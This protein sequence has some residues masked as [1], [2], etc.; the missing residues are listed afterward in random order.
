MRAGARCSV[1]VALL[2]VLLPAPAAGQATVRSFLT[3]GADVPVGSTFIVSV[4]VTGAGRVEAA[5]QA[6]DLSAWADY[7]GSGRSSQVSVVN[8]RTTSTVTWQFRY[9]AAGEGQHP[10]PPVTVEADGATFESNALEMRVVPARPGAPSSAGSADEGGLAPGDLFLTTEVPRT[11]VREGEPLP[12]SYRIWTRVNVTSYT[13]VEIPEMQGFWVEEVPSSGSPQVEQRTRNGEQYTTAV[14]RRVVVV[15][16]GPGRRTMEPLGIDAQV[17]VRR[18]GG[19]PFDR[20]FGGGLFGTTVETLRVESEPLTIEVDP[21]PPGRPEPFSGVVGDLVVRSE[22]D[23]SEVAANEAVTLTV[24]VSGSGSIRTVAPPELD[25]P[26]AFEVFPPETSEM[27]R[28]SVGGID[29]TKTFEYVLIPRAPGNHTI[30]PIRYGYFDDRTDAYRVAEAPAI[31]IRVT[32]VAGPSGPGGR[33]GVTQLRQDI[34]FIHLAA[35]TLRSASGGLARRPGFWIVFLLPLVGVAGAMALR[36]HR[37]RLE[38]DV[39]W[40]RGRNAGRVARKR[41]AEARRLA[42]GDDPRAFHAEVARALRGFVADKLN[43]AEAGMQRG[44]VRRGLEGAGVPEELVVR[45]TACLD[46]CD[47]QRF[48]PGTADAAEM[49]RFLDDASGI[50]SD[51]DRAV[52]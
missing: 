51:L 37:E 33:S 18:G 36:R 7:Q 20:I 44:D 1:L 13:V 45:T 4:E 52:R 50:M 29:G 25:L 2:A 16:T 27:I 17:R 34:R 47:R 8:G 48:A 38:G 10:V 30:P 12:V 3:P 21:L 24:R 39:A 14:V 23:R 42:G 46:H 11:R 40:A 35:P 15:P 43:V 32:G 28:T 9:R 19:D 49:R 31:P 6:P 22:V 26:D 41:F 5:P